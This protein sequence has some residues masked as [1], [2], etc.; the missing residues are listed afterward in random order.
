MLSNY[1]CFDAEYSLFCF[2]IDRF[3]D[4]RLVDGRFLVRIPLHSGKNQVA[5]GGKNDFK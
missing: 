4:L 3:K 1:I 5:C 2:M